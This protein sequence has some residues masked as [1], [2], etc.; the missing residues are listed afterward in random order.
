MHISFVALAEQPFW[1]TVNV[2]VSQPVKVSELY[3]PPVTTLGEPDHV[4]G[5]TPG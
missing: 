3:W 1:V 5:V 2:S 4:P